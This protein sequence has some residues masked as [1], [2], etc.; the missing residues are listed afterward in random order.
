MME[1]WE[2]REPHEGRLTLTRSEGGPRVIA[3]VR[4]EACAG[5]GQV[6]GRDGEVL[7]AGWWPPQFMS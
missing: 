4:D 6:R 2:G 5:V 1:A 7:G 3:E